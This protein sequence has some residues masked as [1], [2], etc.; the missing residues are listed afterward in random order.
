M[1]F[2]KNYIQFMKSLKQNTCTKKLKHYYVNI[3]KNKMKKHYKIGI[4]ILLFAYNLNA[5]SFESDFVESNLKGKIKSI[6]VHKFALQERFGKVEKTDSLYTFNSFYNIK[7][8]LTGQSIKGKFYKGLSYTI[9]FDSLGRKCQ[10]YASESGMHDLAVDNYRIGYVY[11]YDKKGFLEQ[12]KAYT[13]AG[14]QVSDSMH[15]GVYTGYLDA[16]WIHKYDNNGKVIETNEYDGIGIQTRKILY[17]YDANK[18]LIKKST[19]QKSTIENADMELIEEVNYLVLK[20]GCKIESVISAFSLAHQ[21]TELN[22]NT[23]DKDGNIIEKKYYFD[24]RKPKIGSIKN[25]FTFKYEF[26]I[27]KNWVKKIE[28]KDNKPIYIS[29]RVIEYY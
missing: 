28:F 20:N 29:E 14:A 5:Q 9:L 3:T 7:G 23:S 16:V 22:E 13:I 21:T 10:K 6:C 12:V 1:I 2:L 8:D 15:F 4:I 19:Y 27:N 11:I 18:K 25:I 26:D 24:E 17:K